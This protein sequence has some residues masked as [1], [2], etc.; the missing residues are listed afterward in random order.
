[1]ALEL[2]GES[3]EQATREETRL[4]ITFERLCV[5]AHVVGVDGLAERFLELAHDLTAASPELAVQS[6]LQAIVEA[7]I[8]GRTTSCGRRWI[9]CGASMAMR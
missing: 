9:S 2:L 6:M 4:A 3:L 8:S 1:M 5:E 7:S